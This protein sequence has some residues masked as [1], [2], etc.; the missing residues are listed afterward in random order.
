MKKPLKNLRIGSDN[1]RKT[2]TGSSTPKKPKT[3]PA[4]RFYKVEI[5]ISAEEYAWGLPYFGEQKYLQ[6]FVS[7]AYREKVKRAEA[8]DEENQGG[9]NER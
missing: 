7:E 5:R 8:H 3:S 1:K 6:K 2:K 4:P 9:T